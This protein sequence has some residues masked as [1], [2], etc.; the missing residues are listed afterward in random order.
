MERMLP[1]TT[2][3][4]VVRAKGR[5]TVPAPARKYLELAEGDQVMVVVRQ[6]SL[7]LIPV[8]LAAPD[9]LW[10]LNRTVRNR[11]EDAEDDFVAGR[12]V[13]I[14]RPGRLL[15]AVEQVISREAAEPGTERS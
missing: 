12:V 15:D 5:I 13:E 10:T 1:K 7:E 11:I 9:R 4:A 6:T 8:S 3:R 14:Q 2:L